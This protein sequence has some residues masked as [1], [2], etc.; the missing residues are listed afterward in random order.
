MSQYSHFDAIII[1]T[2]AGGGTLAYALAPSGKRILILERGGYLPR[3]KENW[4]THAVFT[5]LRYKPNETWY[6]SEGN[7]YR[8]P[9]NYCVGGNTKFY[10]ATLMRFREKDFGVIKHYKGLSPA[11]PLSYEDLEPY[12]T[13]AE[14]LYH[15]HGQRGIDP[16]EPPASLPYR[17]PPIS[18]ELRIEQLAAD[19]RRLG[20]HPFPLPIGIMLDEENPHRSKCIRCDTCG[21]YPCLVNAKADSHTICI[22]PAL[23]H[24]NVTLLTHANVTRLETNTS[25]REVTKVHV[26]RQGVLEKYS[27]DIVVVSC[28]AINSAAL[29]LRSANDKHPE[30]LANSSGVVGRNY[31]RHVKSSVIAISKT[32]NPTIFQKTL[33]FNDFY[34]GSQEWDYPMGNVQMIGKTNAEVLK[35]QELPATTSVTKD[36]IAKH[37]LDLCVISEDLPDPNN[38]VTLSSKG[39]IVFNYAANNTEGH[40]RLVAKLEHMLNEIG[41]EGQVQ[42]RSVYVGQ[43][44]SVD[45]VNHQC[46]TIRFGHDPTTSALDVYCKAHDLDNLYV[47]DASFFVS[48]TATNPALTVIANALRVAD[49]LL[50]RLS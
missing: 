13:K 1:G 34:F 24:A 10:G 19:L 20:L 31:M 26:E 7:A 6:D 9:T 48:S 15:V 5:E 14:E 42:S 22:Q 21:G 32:P 47:V 46:G 8:C 3:E 17:F 40:N 2:G 39:E 33:G 37:T 43:N 38:R 49:R 30:G 12:Y 41:C 50:E 23:E 18:N 27:A 29:L 36:N 4:D 45:G 25:G 35:N 44:N 16:T 11:W 28:G